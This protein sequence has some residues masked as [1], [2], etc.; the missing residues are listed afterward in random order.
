MDLRQI[1]DLMQAMGRTGM[2]RLK[3][4]SGDVELELEHGANAAPKDRF[5][6]MPVGNPMRGDMQQHLSN[7]SVAAPSPPVVAKEET[8][9][10]EIYDFITSPMVGTFYSS[11]SPDD[12]VFVKV[13]DTVSPGTVVCIIEA[14][15]VMN[16]VKAGINGVVV[17][18]LMENSHPVE[19]GTK[20]FR[21]KPAG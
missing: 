9:P 21:I 7:A 13:G 14:M 16:E 18:V 8:A 11:A 10:E 5:V 2:H 20:L 3:Y 12:P 15:K 4:K 19:F 1:K 6:E 17:E